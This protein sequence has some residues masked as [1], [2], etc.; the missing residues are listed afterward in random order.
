M[1]VTQ[2]FFTLKMTLMT[3]KSSS[4]LLA[5]HICPSES[6]QGYRV[7]GVYRNQP[8]IQFRDEDKG[9]DKREIHHGAHQLDTHGP[10]HRPDSLSGE[11]WT[12][13]KTVGRMVLDNRVKEYYDQFENADKALSG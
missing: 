9:K 13:R 5:D 12:D 2:T 4:F 8:E 1:K 7:I 11:Y 3:P 6:G 10:A